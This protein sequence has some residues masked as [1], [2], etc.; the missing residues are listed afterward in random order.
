[1]SGSESQSEVTKGVEAGGPRGVNGIEPR[2]RPRARP[3]RR[4]FDLRDFFIPA[5]EW[6]RGESLANT[7]KFG[8]LCYDI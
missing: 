1:M 7:R 5:R 6:V 8:N 2:P 4:G 3:A